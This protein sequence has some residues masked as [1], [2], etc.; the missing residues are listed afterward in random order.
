MN[1]K[2]KMTSLEWRASVGLASIFGL[3]ML[4]LFLI[5]PV[6]AVYASHLPGGDNRTLI[7]LA[8]GTYGLTQAILQIPLGML[9]DRYGRKRIIYIGLL[10]FALGSFV[11]ASAHSI[12]MVILGRAIQGSGAIAAAVIALAADLTR[13]EH[14]TKAMA[15]IGMTIGVTFS[16]SLVLAPALNQWIGVPGIF[17]LTGVLALLGMLVVFAGVPNPQ[18]T[19]FHSDAEAVPAQFMSVLRNTQLLRLNF[20]IFSLHVVLMSMFVVIPFALIKT[21]GLDVNHH[22]EVYLPVMLA[23]FVLMV[24]AIIYGEKKAKLKQVFVAAIGLMLAAQLLLIF[25]VRDFWGIVALLFAFF[26]AF[27]I[28]EATLPSL[29]SKIAPAGSK[30]TAIGVYN[31]FEFF[32]AFLGGAAGGLLSHYY[33]AAYVFAFGSA[34]I[35]IWLLLAMSMKAPPA[36]RSMMYHVEEMD[37]ER[38]KWL[39]QR[40]AALDGVT[41]AVVVAEEGVAYLKVRMGGWDEQGALNLIG[42]RKEHGISE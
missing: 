15:L 26:V 8:L 29:I 27:N 6:F 10:L 31:S 28:L 3:R 36:V 14:R 7:G 11:A 19:R 21:S 24:P 17:A 38:A 30:G 9:S 18:I 23:S 1:D 39:S 20:G 25:L 13:E 2:Y 22:W 42:E 35:G 5:L 33:G 41:E 16:I 37:A 4:G 32:G 40:L 12:H 34:L